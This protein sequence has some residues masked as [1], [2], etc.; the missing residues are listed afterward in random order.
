M[1]GIKFERDYGYAPGAPFWITWDGTEEPKRFET[2]DEA[3]AS[4]AHEVAELPG[5]KPVHVLCCMAT[6]TT[7]VQVI[8]TRFDPNRAP[9]PEVVDEAPLPPP[10][11]AFLSDEDQVAF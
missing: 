1:I 9:L 11:S 4:A 8:G 6:V 7:D 2:R 3:E 5:Y 10:A